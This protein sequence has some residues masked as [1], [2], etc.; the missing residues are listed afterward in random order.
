MRSIRLVCGPSV[1]CAV[2]PFGVRS[3]RLVCG[4]SVGCLLVNMNQI[5]QNHNALRLIIFYLFTLTTNK[6]YVWSAHLSNVNHSTAGFQ[7]IHIGF[8]SDLSAKGRNTYYK[9]AFICGLNHANQVLQIHGYR[10]VPQIYNNHGDVLKSIQGMTEMYFNGIQA[11]IGP[12][13]SCTIEANV[14]A[15]WNMPMISYV[16]IM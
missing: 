14:V 12:E 3:V 5:I 7:Q 10:L 16:S 15:A 1:W 6:K 8:I 2:H 4:L 9:G 13:D 11:F